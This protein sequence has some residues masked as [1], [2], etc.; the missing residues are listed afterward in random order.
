MN[1]LKRPS[2]L[3]L[4]CLLP[5]WDGAALAQYSSGA[6]PSTGNMGGANLGGFSGGS[7]GGFAPVTSG[8]TRF[9]GSTPSITTPSSGGQRLAQPRNVMRSGGYNIKAGPVQMSFDAGMGVE[10]NS[11]VN[12]SEEDPRGSLVLTP[13]V[14]MNLYWPITRLNNVSLALG[15]GYNYYLDDPDLGGQYLLISPAT[16]LMFNIFIQDFIITIYE[17]PSVT[18]NPTENPT[19]SNAVNYT[20]FNNTAGIDVLWDL[21]DLQFGIGYANQIRYSLNDDYTN[22]DTI[23]NQIYVNASAM[24]QPFLRV[25]VEG[26]VYNTYYFEERPFRTGGG[27]GTVTE[28]TSNLNNSVGS[29]AGLFA[30]GNIS[31]FTSWS[32]GVGWQIT[33]FNETNNPLNTGNAS[34]PYF[35]FGVSNELN[36]FFTH[37][38]SASFQ[39]EPS[40]E[41]NFLQAF[42]V[43]YSFNWIL[44]RNWS[45]GGGVFYQNGTESPGPE[46]EDFNRVGANVGL[47]YELTKNLVASL[48]YSVISKGST[49]LADGYNQQI[50]GLNLNYNF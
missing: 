32:A 15:L 36:R 31:R 12:V 26:N 35:Y 16:E 25:G 7:R 20:F 37:S 41:S 43:G 50:F 22:Q 39:T 17:R 30:M 1:A 42:N 34:N 24:V 44:I 4:L 23:S 49:V 9:Q 47:G 14:G 11:N 18:E 38:F 28:N 2:L 40:Y 45:L 5:L 29:S 46:S 21:N 3:I 8:A 13:R 48:Y 6:V 10:Y 33:Q 27:T 19:V